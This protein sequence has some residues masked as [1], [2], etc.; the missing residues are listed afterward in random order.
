MNA[1]CK[2]VDANGAAQ[3]ESVSGALDRARRGIRK[4]VPEGQ[5]DVKG[6]AP[7]ARLSIGAAAV[8]LGLLAALHLVSPEL[9]P[10]W[11]MVSEYANG[12]HGWMLSCM[13]AS[14]ALSSWALAFALRSQVRRRAGRIG[15]ALLVAAGIGEAMAS[16]FDIHRHPWHEVAG[17]IGVLG[18]PVAALMISV[19]LGHER[20][21]HSVK[22]G[23]LWA[24]NLTW[25]S[26]VLMAGGLFA[27]GVSYHRVRGAIPAG[28]H[29][30]PSTAALPHGV[31]GGVGYA[32]RLLVVTYC[33]WTAIAAWHVTR[34]ERLAAGGHR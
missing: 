22:K 7:A 11:R 10:S 24:A 16:V 5:E 25:V 13:F 4:V 27:L 23:L 34:L 26:V 2:F 6:L 1:Q 12:R 19:S 17:G 32:N 8:T 31:I 3:P 15:W 29:A 20:P 33:V 18:L 9:D 28:G 14:W 21:W 30:W